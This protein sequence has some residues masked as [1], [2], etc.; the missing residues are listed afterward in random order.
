MRNFSVLAAN[1]SLKWHMVKPMRISIRRGGSAVPLMP[2]ETGT[3][4]VGSPSSRLLGETHRVCNLEIPEHE[5]EHF[6]LHLQTFGSPTL[7]YWWNG[8]H[9]IERPQPGSLILL[10]PG[11]R[12]RLRWEGPSERLVV[13]LD[14]NY[15][16]TVVEETEFSANPE[17][18][19]RW[20][21]R[22]VALQLILADIGRECSSGWSLGC[23]YSDLLS[24]K[25][26]IVLL[27]NYA[28]MPLTLPLLRGGLPS[29]TLRMCLEYIT[30]N[31]HREI[32]LAEVAGIASL[33]QFHFAR[34]FRGATGQSPHQYH[35]DQRISR[36]K[37][38][39]R[40]TGDR[41]EEIG[42]AVGF[43]RATSFSRTFTSREG[44]S[45]RLWRDHFAH[46]S[47]SSLSRRLP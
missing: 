44:I 46:Q 41:I 34:L 18:Y 17:F 7:E 3:S 14:A 36:A 31:L 26:A 40:T 45:P 25:L 20:H 12:D 21:L 30:A 19:A 47:K 27:R 32:R 35:L 15:M 9:G 13:S 5:H 24:L 33:S 42:A 1:L 39:L 23:L 10:P 2:E 6:C 8:T 38:L 29:N 11:T 43:A 16:R 4:V 22:D 28:S 37:C